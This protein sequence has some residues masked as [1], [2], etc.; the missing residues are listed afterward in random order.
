M[1]NLLFYRPGIAPGRLFWAALSARLQGYR[2]HKPSDA[3]GGVS[4]VFLLPAFNPLEYG[5]VGADASF[6][7]PV[8]MCVLNYPLWQFLENAAFSL[9]DSAYSRIGRFKLRNRAVGSSLTLYIGFCVR[10][11]YKIMRFLGECKASTL[12]FFCG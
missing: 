10:L 4:M 9:A 8:P 1:P 3:A 6:Q 7:A 2:L 12:G 5:A 11:G